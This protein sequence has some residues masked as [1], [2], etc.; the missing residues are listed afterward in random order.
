M[1]FELDCVHPAGGCF[2]YFSKNKNHSEQIYF[3]GGN[4]EAGPVCPE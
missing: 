1:A 4:E 2:I 3:V